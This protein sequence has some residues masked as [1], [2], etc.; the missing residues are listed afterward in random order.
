MKTLQT[1]NKD[2]LQKLE[3]LT[4]ENEKSSLMGEAI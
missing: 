2:L 4:A 1:E 3:E